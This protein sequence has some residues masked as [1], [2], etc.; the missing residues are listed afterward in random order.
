ML[1]GL[2]FFLS[3]QKFSVRVQKFVL[4]LQGTSRRALSALLNAWPVVFHTTEKIFFSHSHHV[5]FL[6]EWSTPIRAADSATIDD[7]EI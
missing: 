3:A 7:A 1:E 6:T 4:C 2:L 5:P